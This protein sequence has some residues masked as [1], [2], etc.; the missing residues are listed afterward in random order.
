[1]IRRVD[2]RAV[3]RFGGSLGLASLAGCS[4]L[5]GVLGGG[6]SD[7]WPMY[8]GG[9]EHRGVNAAAAGPGEDLSVRWRRSADELATAV[10]DEF[11][12]PRVSEPVA[13]DGTVYAALSSSTA[14]FGLHLL[15]LDAESGDLDW[16]ERVRDRYVSSLGGRP[17]PPTVADRT[18]VVAAAG[19]VPGASAVAVDAATGA[20]RWR[21]AR[22]DGANT[23]SAATASDDQYHFAGGITHA[24]EGDGDLVW[25]Y[26]PPKREEWALARSPPTVTADGVYVPTQRSLFALDR[27]GERRWV[28]DLVFLSDLQ[29]S[30]TGPGTPVAGD[31]LYVPSGALEIS[32]DGRLVAIDPATGET[33]WEFKPD[34][35]PDRR[36]EMLQ[37]IYQEYDRR[38]NLGVGVY[39]TPA[40]V[41]GTL[42]ALGQTLPEE[43]RPASVPQLFAIDAASGERQWAT[44]LPD[45]FGLTPPVVAGGTVYVATTAGVT[46]IDAASGDRLAT[47]SVTEAYPQ[48]LA[49]AGDA[50]YASDGRGIAAA[51]PTTGE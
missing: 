35:D 20:E 23:V 29:G 28:R 8:Q 31:L 19:S 18:V 40:L 14:A 45:R 5:S 4:G 16:H 39:A 10:A 34:Y 26:A 12:A 1:M 37:T 21:D 51:G 38:P 2:R 11:R 46:A 15:A 42:Y 30:A 13:I 49:V 36:E 9:P 41:D 32:G 43:T 44:R 27:D 7:A 17:V 22:E 25:E 50:I 24:L 47:R 33:Q 48:G 3:L 6:G